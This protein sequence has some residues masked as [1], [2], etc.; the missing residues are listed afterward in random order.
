M[1]TQN[2]ILGGSS[3]L[4]C[5]VLF[6]VTLF[7]EVTWARNGSRYTPIVEDPFCKADQNVRVSGTNLSCKLYN[8]L[9]FL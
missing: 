5:N 8:H 9:K 4:T 7:G 6:G 2:A 1:D 3:V